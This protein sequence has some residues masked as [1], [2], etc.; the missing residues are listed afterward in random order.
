MV[1][2]SHSTDGKCSN[3]KPDASVKLNIIKWQNAKKLF[4]SRF[5]CMINLPFLH[6]VNLL[7]A[8]GSKNCDRQHLNCNLTVP[9]TKG[10]SQNSWFSRLTSEV[11]F[12][13]LQNRFKIDAYLGA[14]PK[15]YFKTIK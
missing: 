8:S 7:E 3:S 12:L 10:H 6:I 9:K 5:E 14:I 1:I 11:L 2:Q 13:H 4:N 15:P